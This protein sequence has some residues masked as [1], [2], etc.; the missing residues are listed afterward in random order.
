MV[1]D[2]LKEG[3]IRPD[4]YAPELNPVYGAMLAHYG[5]VADPCRVRDPNRK[6]TVEAA[7]QHTQATALKGRRFESIEARDRAIAR[8][9]GGALGGAAHPRAQEAPGAGDVPMYREELPHLRALPPEGFRIFKQAVRTVDDA[10]LVQIEGSYYAALPAAPHSEVSVRIFD[11]EIEILDAA[12]RLLRRHEK[13]LRKGAFVIVGSDRLFNPSRES[14]RLLARV[15]KIGPHTA[16][17]AQEIF[18]RMGHPGQRAI[19]T[20]W[21]TSRARARSG[22]PT[23]RRC[24]SACTQRSAPPTPQYAARWSARAQPPPSPRSRSRARRS[25]PSPSINRSGRRT[26]RLTRRRTPMAMSI[27]ELER[28]LRGL[29]LSGMGATLQARAQLKAAE[30]LLI[31]DLFLRKLPAQAGDEFADVLMSRYEK[32]STIL[33]SNRPL[34][35]WAKLLGDVVLVTPLLSHRTR[36][37]Y[38]TAT[39]SDCQTQF[40]RIKSPRPAARGGGVWGGHGWRNLRWPPG[41]STITSPRITRNRNRSSGLPR[42]M[43]FCKR[44]SAPMHG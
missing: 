28:A 12:G 19:L 22:A 29:R 35:D 2:N 34:E 1:L 11:R 37:V 40:T 6:G 31:D 27:T 8:T 43:I 21:R 25:V 7:I 16:A 36:G 24:A 38:Y 3:V 4:L 26:L 33:T 18:A 10:A 14:A 44:S 42:H 9:L 41:P 13:S 23:S 30:L 32:A 20:D 39:D 17:L 15:E 5:V